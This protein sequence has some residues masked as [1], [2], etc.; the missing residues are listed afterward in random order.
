MQLV[1]FFIEPL[2]FRKGLLLFNGK[3]METWIKVT[4]P[5]LLIFGVNKNQAPVFFIS[6]DVRTKHGYCH[7]KP[8]WK[9]L[10]KELEQIVLTGQLNNPARYFPD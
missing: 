2:S 5:G 8:A 10:N 7:S 9:R 6:A 1:L 4:F 3:F